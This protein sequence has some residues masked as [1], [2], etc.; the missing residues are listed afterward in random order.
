MPTGA[1]P[2]PQPAQS[3]PHCSLTLRALRARDAATCIMHRA[4]F[5]AFLYVPVPPH[6]MTVFDISGKKVDASV[7]PLLEGDHLVL[8]CEVRGGKCSL[9]YDLLLNR[10]P[11]EANAKCSASPPLSYHVRKHLQEKIQSPYSARCS[12]ENFT[13]R[14]L[15]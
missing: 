14:F 3:R 7:G 10:T 4:S 5:R 9:L 12:P 1:E 15:L 8:K 6:S 2:E 11:G 13:F